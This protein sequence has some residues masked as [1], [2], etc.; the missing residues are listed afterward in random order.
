[1][2]WSRYNILA[3]SPTMTNTNWCKNK[4]R[5]ITIIRMAERKWE[6]NEPDV[7]MRVGFAE[8]DWRFSSLK[9]LIWYHRYF[10]N[11]HLIFIGPRLQWRRR[12]SSSILTLS[13]LTNRRTQA[14]SK[15]TMF[16]LAY[17]HILS[18][19]LGFQVFQVDKQYPDML[20]ELHNVANM[21]N[22]ICVK[23]LLAIFFSRKN[24]K[25]TKVK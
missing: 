18:L 2:P 10:I 16:V 15:I 13:F 4:S 3:F 5:V 24:D 9:L 20:T 12:W 23:I 11:S 21:A 25:F 14:W 1:M 22:N 17:N 19:S 6:N 7:N 8:C